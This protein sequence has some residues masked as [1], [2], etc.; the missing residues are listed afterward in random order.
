MELDVDRAASELKDALR[1]PDPSPAHS[2]L[3]DSLRERYES[4][5]PG[6]LEF[7]PSERRSLAAYSFAELIDKADTEWQV[8]LYQENV[9][10]LEN[11]RPVRSLWSTVSAPE[12]GLS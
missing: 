7:D 8:K 1:S 5:H 10:L 2:Q 9:R 12:L 4:I 3:V 11:L 6:M